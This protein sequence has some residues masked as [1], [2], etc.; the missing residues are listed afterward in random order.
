MPVF[1]R[2]RKN[3]ELLRHIRKWWS[4]R[5]IPESRRGIDRALIELGMSTPEQMMIAS[6]GLSLSDSYWM[7]PVG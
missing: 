5:A 7:R 4:K 2:G 1:T 6:Q 3:E